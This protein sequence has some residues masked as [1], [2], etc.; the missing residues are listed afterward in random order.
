MIKIITAKG[1]EF[2]I[3]WAG[4]SKLDGSLRF[5][6]ADADLQSLIPVF[7]DKEQT[8]TLTRVFDEDSREFVGYTRVIRIAQME[9]GVVIGLMKE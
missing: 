3:N 1:I 2:A 7:S 8:K 9:T 4:V 5:E 6:V